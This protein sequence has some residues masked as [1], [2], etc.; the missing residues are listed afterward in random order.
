MTNLQDRVRAEASVCERKPGPKG[1]PKRPE[2]LPMLRLAERA[3]SGAARAD[4]CIRE[5]SAWPAGQCQH[6]PRRGG[7]QPLLLFHCYLRRAS[8]RT[9]AKSAFGREFHCYFVVINSGRTLE[10]RHTGAGRGQRQFGETNPRCASATPMAR[11]T[12]LRSHAAHR[13]RCDG[14]RWLRGYRNTWP[15]E[16]GCPGSARR[17]SRW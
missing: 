5:D 4:A 17:S 12:S 6:A 10:D 13:P 14:L 15:P 7:G 3:R 16:G 9:R 1:S 2:H 11:V 8:R